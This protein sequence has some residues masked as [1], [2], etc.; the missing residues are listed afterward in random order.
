MVPER[1]ILR[2]GR[3]AEV[4]RLEEA[5]VA[6]ERQL[7]RLHRQLG[8][9]V[10]GAAHDII[11]LHRMIL[12]SPE[13]ADESR[14]LISDDCFGAEWAVS[15]ALERIRSVF[16]QLEDSYF[17]DR[18]GDFEA[19]GE[20][21]LRVLL[22]LPEPGAARTA[23][24]GAVAV[25]T[26]MGPLALLQLQR[27]GVEAVV[28]EG[29]G[30][31]SHAAI[32]ARGLGLPYI[33]GV[34][35]VCGDVKAGATVIVDGTRGEMI[36]EPDAETLR[37]YQA[38]ADA[39]RERERR[40]P[41][42]RMVPSVTADGVEI[43]LAANV[44]SVA[45]VSTA[46]AAGAESIGLFRTEFLYLERPDL[47]SEE[48]HYSDAVA[49]L[50]AAGGRP[51][52]FRT[53]DLGGDKLPLAIKVP[54][55]P[56]PALGV[57]STR[58]SLQ[59][60]DILRPQLRAFYRAATAG[61]LRFM[62][63]L[64]TTVGELR[65]LRAICDEVRAEL[66]AEKIAHDPAVAIG[67]MVET[68][69]AALTADHFARHCDFLSVG[70]NDLIQYAFATDREND[71]VAHLRSPLHPAVLRLLRGLVTNARD[72][73]VP[74]SICGNMAGDPF[75]SVLLI[76][77]GFR[78]LSMDRSRIPVVKEVV[79]AFT[80]AGAE[81]LAHEALDKEDETEVRELIHTR[82]AG[83]FSAEM[84]ELLVGPEPA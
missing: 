65:Q 30:A 15:Q 54:P 79:R 46:V 4:A 48:E 66:K 19:V 42:T 62:F 23:A 76:G 14:R 22:G 51:V 70:T 77:L 45:G 3:D 68:P 73:N 63:P 67:V 8:G 82:L 6:A 53:L 28:S 83:R 74:L 2:N 21:L 24:R 29:G 44:E 39:R 37:M 31:T 12:R 59:R 57:R 17:R 34:R 11:D 25:A 64:V 78:D 61:P 9:S 33:V 7:E 38:R 71:D 10:D 55:G 72:A 80:L 84:E 75:M 35:R 26:D 20:R 56:N 16:A 36:V 27:A 32:L 43:H 81:S 52:V 49:A 47:P 1:R 18:S 60:P 69:S 41:T 5:T 58:F 50:R 13:L 40:V